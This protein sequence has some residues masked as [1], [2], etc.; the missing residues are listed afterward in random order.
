MTEALAIVRTPLRLTLGGGGTD[1][2]F[3]RSRFG[4]D[5]LTVAIS[6]CVTV[7]GRLGRLDGG[8]RFSHDVTDITAAG[9]EVGNPYLREALR[10]TGTDRPCE[11]TSMGPVPPGTGLGNSGAFAIGLLGVLHALAGREPSPVELIEQAHE[12]EVGRLG[13]PIGKQDHYA[14]GLGGPRRLVIDTSGTVTATWIAATPRTLRL[15]DE[16]LLLFYTRRRRDSV[17]QLVVPTAGTE[18]SRR[19]EQLDHIRKLGDETRVALEAGRLDDIPPLMREH[20]HIKRQREASGLWDDWLSAACAQGAEAGKIVGAGGGGFLLV[21]AGP[22]THPRVIAAL[23]DA[24][25]VHVPF[26]F[27]DK[28]TV[29]T[30]LGGRP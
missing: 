12:L 19:I 21:Y 28:G 5:M 9:A 22:D 20:W 15:L 29:T 11:I 30:R 10:L 8:H 26:T 7:V 14:C 16:R 27:T 2:P 24:G 25:L 1:L 17:A 13:M 23:R 3:Y 18:L 6:L 4:G